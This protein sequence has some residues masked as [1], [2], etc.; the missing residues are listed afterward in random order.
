MNVLLKLKNKNKD[1]MF[2]RLARFFRNYSLVQ[3]KILKNLVLD[4]TDAP[5]L[6]LKFKG[7]F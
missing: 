3:R 4:V 7:V 6:F 5:Q 2:G 1:G